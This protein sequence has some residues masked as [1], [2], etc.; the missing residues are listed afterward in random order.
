MDKKKEFRKKVLNFY[1][2]N[3]REFPWRNTTDPYKI[4][5]SELMLQQ[6]QT[7]RVLPKYEEFLKRFKG[8]EELAKA[9]Q[10]DV[11]RAW[12]GLGYNRRALYLKRISKA[13]FWT[14]QNDEW[15][16]PEFL[17]TLPGIGPNTAGS[18]YVFVTNKPYIFI[19]TNIR[20]VF[21]HEFFEDQDSISDKQILELVEKTLDRK[22]PREWYYALMDYGAYLA[23]TQVNPNRKSKHYTKQSKFGGSMRQTRGRILKILLKTGKI[24]LAELVKNFE[25]KANFNEALKQLENEKFLAKSTKNVVELI[26]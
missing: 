24:E 8:F 9:S 22:K 26:L 21:I 13:R 12:N 11:L 4:L 6:T 1:Q 25:D 5:I 19:E 14:S 15:L 20:R 10:E 18:I 2:K 3:K 17:K 16:N 7:Y 23:K